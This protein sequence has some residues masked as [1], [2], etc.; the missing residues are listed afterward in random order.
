MCVVGDVFVIFQVFVDC[1]M[2]F[3]VL[4][5]FEWVY[6]GIVV[7]QVDYKIDCDF[8]VVGVVQE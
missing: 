8:V 5:F 7:V 6:L 4:E 3:E 1:W 2:G